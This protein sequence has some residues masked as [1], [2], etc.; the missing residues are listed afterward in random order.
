KQRPEGLSE[1]HER[2]AALVDE[3]GGQAAFA[4][5]AGISQSG[6]NRILQGGQ[7]TLETLIAIA[8]ASGLG[9]EQLVTG[10]INQPPTAVSGVAAVLAGDVF[11][12]VPR[13]DVTASAG[14]GA[15]ALTEIV[16]EE[17]AFRRDWLKEIGVSPQSAKL[18]SATGD[19]ME[20]L[21]PD[22]AL[23]LIDSSIREV[24]NGCIYVIVKDGDLLVKRVHRKID[25][26]ISLISENPRYDPE[27]I[28]ADFLDKLHIVGRVRWVGRSI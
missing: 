22:G 10:G 2:L 12:L 18:L 11:E 4:G 27:V 23:M 26:S 24:R 25:G 17:M 7:P 20:P 15:V 21:I 19:S 28:S 14:S 16:S 9:L 1:F 3:A 5:K 13:Y 8:S 6:L